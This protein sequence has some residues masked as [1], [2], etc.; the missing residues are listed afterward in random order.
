VGHLALPDSVET[1]VEALADPPGFSVAHDRARRV[2]MM[3]T[4]RS[5]LCPALRCLSEV[6]LQDVGDPD[7]KLRTG[8]RPRNP[9]PT[10]VLSVSIGIEIIE[11]LR[12]CL[13]VAGG[14]EDPKAQPV[15]IHDAGRDDG[16]ADDGLRALE[17]LKN[18]ADG[19]IEPARGSALVVH[20]VNAIVARR[21]R[22]GQSSER[23]SSE[24]PRTKA[25]LATMRS[26]FKRGAVGLAVTIALLCAVDVALVLARPQRH[27][28]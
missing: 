23:I 22:T 18:R 6:F 25:V 4:R 10:T 13:L 15:E 20:E 9:V 14:L 21:Q 17:V 11:Q 8:K 28:D 12:Q 1:F 2:R 7:Q 19:L 5:C 26:A 16:E 3:W 24:L 27:S